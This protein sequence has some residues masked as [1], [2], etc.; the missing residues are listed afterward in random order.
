MTLTN[1]K[2]QIAWAW[3]AIPPWQDLLS[4]AR[5]DPAGGYSQSDLEIE[6]GSKAP[7]AATARAAGR[8]AQSRRR[9]NQVA[10][11]QRPHGALVDASSVQSA[12][13][14]AR[15]NVYQAQGWEFCVGNYW[16]SPHRLG[17]RRRCA[18]LG[19]WKVAKRVADHLGNNRA[20]E[21]ESGG[22]AAV[23]DASRKMGQYS[24]PACCGTGVALCA[25]AV[26]RLL[27]LPIL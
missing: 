9:S 5:S 15:S 11:G 22:D 26:G 21:E 2:E 8:A 4:G 17:W 14:L 23:Q 13:A 24:L 1:F 25:A 6:V 18:V 7:S 3:Q 19:D 27:G 16:A 10:Y 20:S 12:E